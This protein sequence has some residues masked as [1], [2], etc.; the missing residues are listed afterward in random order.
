MFP[1]SISC[2]THLDSH[3]QNCIHS[4]KYT[5]FSCTTRHTKRLNSSF[6]TSAS[7]G[8]IC[9]YSTSLLNKPLK[10][11]SLDSGASIVG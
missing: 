7:D 11:F 5:L 1:L 9:L 8:L 2:K 3:Y 4:E 10:Y 6:A